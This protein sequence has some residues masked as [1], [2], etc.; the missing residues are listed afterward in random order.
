MA[1]LLCQWRDVCERPHSRGSARRLTFAT[2]DRCMVNLGTRGGQEGAVWWPGRQVPWRAGDWRHAPPQ[3]R[4]PRSGTLWG[5]PPGLLGTYP[6]VA[7]SA[8]CA[9]NATQFAPPRSTPLLTGS[10]SV[11]TFRAPARLLWPPW[12]MQTPHA[13]R[14]GHHASDSAPTALAARPTKP[15]PL[16]RPSC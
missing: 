11:V 13:Q 14:A 12:G 10:R 9:A 5:A 4:M 3:G 7:Q 8:A 15:C 2:R 6:H 16:R 1:L